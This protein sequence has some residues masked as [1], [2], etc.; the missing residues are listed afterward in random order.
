MTKHPEKKKKTQFPRQKMP[1][2]EPRVRAKN[3]DE[4]PLGL[5]EELAKLE[6]SRCLQ[7]KKPT[8][9]QGCP[10]SIDIPGFIELI[11]R[12]DYRGAAKKLKEAG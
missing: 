1:E 6:A 9:V 7:C 8:C 3:F 11:H 2:Q 4:V 10:V 12:E 5:S